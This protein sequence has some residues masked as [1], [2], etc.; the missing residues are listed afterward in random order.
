M[1]MY[2]FTMYMY[3]YVVMIHIL[4][5][6]FYTMVI[7]MQERMREEGVR[8]PTTQHMGCIFTYQRIRT[9]CVQIFPANVHASQPCA[10][11]F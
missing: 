3:M 5:H 10:V 2:T 8:E 9:S 6:S 1:C 11:L 7:N 4:F